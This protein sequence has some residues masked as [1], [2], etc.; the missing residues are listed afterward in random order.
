MKLVL[1]I[2]AGICLSGLLLVGG[3]AALVGVGANSAA[4]AITKA[5]KRDTAAAATFKHQFAKVK[6]GDELTGAGGMTKAQVAKLLG[7]PKP[8]SIIVTKGAHYTSVSWSWDF[9]M[10]NGHVLF[11]VDFLNGHATGKSAV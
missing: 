8:R 4:T 9:M 1:K 7:A 2:M 11:S 5:E 6:V 3:C 10:S